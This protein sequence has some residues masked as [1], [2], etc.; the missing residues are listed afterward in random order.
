MNLVFPVE[1]SAE[2]ALLRRTFLEVDK[3]RLSEVLRNLLSNAVKFTPK[4]GS[5]TVGAEL[6]SDVP[7]SSTGREREP[8]PF[9]RISITDTGP[10]ISKVRQLR[11][12]CCYKLFELS[13]YSRRYTL[14]MI[15]VYCGPY[16]RTC[17]AY[18]ARWCRSTRASCREAAGLASDCTV[19]G[20]ESCASLVSDQSH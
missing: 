14:T 3:N 15:Y 1:A 4:G 20:V 19:S 13:V 9:L 17:P 12:R 11:H 10:G 18:S 7:R 8:I 6:I 16:R 5:V 2:A